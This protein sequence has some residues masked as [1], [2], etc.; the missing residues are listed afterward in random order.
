MGRRRL[1]I[2]LSIA[3]V[4]AVFPGFAKA[5]DQL[6]FWPEVD[7]FVKLSPKTRLLFT[8]E[9]NDNRDEPK[10]KWIVG[11]YLDVFVPR[12]RPVLFRRI[13][14][15]D[16]SR[17]QRIVIRAGY[18]FSHTWGTEPAQ[19][20]HR[21]VTDATFRWD[22]LDRILGS[23]RNR[24]EFRFVNGAY[25]WRNR[26]QAKISHD[27]SIKGTTLIPFISAEGSYDS[28][29]QTVS[30]YRYEAGATFPLGKVWAI[31]PYFAR[32]RSRAPSDSFMNF[33]GLTIQAY[34]H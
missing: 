24:F 29:Y 27:I 21:P 12:F 20:E 11:S 26:N 17:N 2:T 3:A 7:A 34:L 6:P 13:S 10:S 31:E 28:Q 19:I 32:Q 8:T 16:E 9:A 14:E 22:F 5:E 18:R 25:S 23:D 30:R 1:K 33:F 4:S 15:L